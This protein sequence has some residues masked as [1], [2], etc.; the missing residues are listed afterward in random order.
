M[1]SKLTP[2]YLELIYEAALKSFWRKTALRKFLRECHV[3]ENF[4]ATWAEDESKRGLLDRLFEKATKSD[5]GRQCLLSMANYLMEQQSFPDLKNWED[6]DAK[7]R[8]AHEAVQKLRRY[9]EQQEQ[10]IASEEEKQKSREEFRKRQEQISRSQ[11]TLQKLSERLNELGK[12]LGTQQAGY[13][14]QSWFYDLVQFSEIDHRR[15]YMHG[16]RQIDGSL[17]HDGTT[18][19]SELKFTTSQVGPVEIGDFY[20]K[21]SSKADNTMGIMVSIS[22][23]TSAAIKEASGEKTPLLLMDH[24]HLYF[25]L[26]GI[27]GMKEVIERIRRHAS[28]TA[29]AY[30]PTSLFNG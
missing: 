24:S 26:S 27:M 12:Q 13:D 3:S 28:Q 4:L 10:E 2:Y 17:T 7:I 9:H 14:F 22:G 11:Q 19:L 23:F 30:L 16:E 20:R 29:E 21:V 1:K 25:V 6:S 18:Y 8:E 5:S 15:P